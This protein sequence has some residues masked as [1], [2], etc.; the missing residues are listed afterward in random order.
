MIKPTNSEEGDQDER[1]RMDDRQG[2]NQRSK[3]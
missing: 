1:V 2:S 3:S